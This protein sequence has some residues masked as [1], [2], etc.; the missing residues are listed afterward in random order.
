M[1]HLS[2]LILYTSHQYFLATM[3]NCTCRVYSGPATSALDSPSSSYSI[4]V[5]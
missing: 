5:D 1:P 2:S 3:K 4:L